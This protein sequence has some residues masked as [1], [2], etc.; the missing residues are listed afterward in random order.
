[1]VGKEREADRDRL[2]GGREREIAR[3]KEKQREIGTETGTETD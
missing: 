1:M 2:R 3:N